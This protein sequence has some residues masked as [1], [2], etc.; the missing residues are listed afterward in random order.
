[1]IEARWVDSNGVHTAQVDR[2]SLRLAQEVDI[3]EVTE[4]KK[5]WKLFQCL[6]KVEY[7]DK[8]TMR[9]PSMAHSASVVRLLIDDSN[10][11]AIM[12]WLQRRGQPFTDPYKYDVIIQ[13]GEKQVIVQGA[14]P[15]PVEVFVDD[16]STQVELVHDGIKV[17][18]QTNV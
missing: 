16:D 6:R 18:G 1:M 15:N 14:W 10:R 13:M 5:K 12:A 8:V 4:K 7:Y 3:V 9:L 17:A 2:E 11:G